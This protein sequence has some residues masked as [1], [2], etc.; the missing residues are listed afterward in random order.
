MA[1]ETKGPVVIE[2][3]QAPDV[4][5]ADAPTVPDQVNVQTTPVTVAAE[6]AARPRSALVVWFWRVAI[7]L[8][9]FVLS[10]TAWNYVTGLLATNPLLGLIA[11][12]LVVVFVLILLGLALREWLALRR[13]RRVDALQKRAVD[14][15]AN[16]DLPAAHGVTKDLEALYRGR[17][18]A[19]WAIAKMHDLREEVLDADGLLAATEHALLA[20]FDTA[21]SQRVEAASRQVATITALVPLALVDVVT[22]LSA[23]LRMIREIAEIYGGRGGTLGSWRLAKSVLTHL[24]ATGAVAFGD[25]MLGSIAGGGILGKLSRRFGEGLVNGAL[26]ARVGVAAIEVCRPLPFVAED[27]P[28]VTGILGRAMAG[29]VSS[30]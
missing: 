23:N 5:P 26:T 30:K 2:L 12:V 1:K 22:A 28:S 16:Q 17:D 21:A 25:D 19:K 11:A 15:A 3:D 7:A 4:N 24:V 6:L 8:F 20:S 9:T 10:L 27:R 29:F 18:D 13:L 14:A